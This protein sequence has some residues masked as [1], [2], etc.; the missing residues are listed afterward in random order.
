MAVERSTAPAETVGNLK[1]IGVAS[2]TMYSSGLGCGGRKSFRF[3][4]LGIVDQFEFLWIARTLNFRCEKCG[5][6]SPVLMPDWHLQ[7][8]LPTS[9]PKQ[10]FSR[11]RS[12]EP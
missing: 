1:Q 3:D 2:F 12:T 9:I 7:D 4:D 10:R 5:N 11:R 6:R 8:R